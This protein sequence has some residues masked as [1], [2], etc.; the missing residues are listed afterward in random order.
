MKHLLLSFLFAVALLLGS[1]T[2]SMAQAAPTFNTTPSVTTVD[3]GKPYSYSA[4][5]T[6]EG[7]LVTTITAPTLPAWMTFST[8]GQ[9]TASLFGNIPY[10]IGIGGVAGDNNG[11]IFAITQDGTTIYQI[12]PDGT[13]TTWKTGL[14]YGS[15]YALDICDGYIY[16]PR[17]S[18]NTNSLTRIP[19]SNPAAAEETV[20]SVY[21]GIL[22][23]TDNGGYLYGADWQTA[24]IYK[25]DKTT[26]AKQVILNNSNGIPS[27][28]PFGLVFDASGNLYIA[29]W[30]NGTILKYNGST[31]TTVLTGLTSPS[32]IRTDK[33]GNFY[34]SLYGGGVRKY[35]PDFS[36]P[37][38]VSNS[39]TDGVMS[40]SFT[41][42]G[43]LV[44]SMYSTNQIY[45]LQTGA[46]IQGTPAKTDVGVYPVVLRATNTSGYTDQSFNV[47]VQ[48]KV[49]PVITTYSPTN[50]ATS[51]VLKPTLSLVF[52]EEVYFGST[53]TIKIYNSSTSALVRSLDL[54][55]TAD[56]ALMSISTDLKTLSI[57]IDQYLPTNTILSMDISAGFVQDVYNNGIPG[58]AYSSNTW[59]FTTLNKMAQTITFP[60][61]SAKTY[62]NAAFTLGNA[63][64]DQGLTVTYTAT[65]PSV[66]SISGNQA[67][68]LKA[69]STTITA[70]QAGDTYN[71]AATSIANTLTVNKVALTVTGLTGV[72]KVYNGSNTATLS[73]T[74]AL[75][76][77]VTGDA[78]NVTLGGTPTA[79]FAQTAVGNNIAITVS[80]Y[81]ISG[82]ASGNY[83]LTQP[84]GLTANITPAAPTV[85]GIS[86]TS[87]PIAGGTSVI[88]T[89]TY[90]TAA[91]AVNFGSTNA[92]SY[93]INSATQITATAPAGSAGAV[94]IIVITVGG[95]SATSSGDQ[96]TYVAAPAVSGISPTYGPTTSGTSVVIT[97]TNLTAASAVKFGSTNATSYTV[98]SAT[99]ITASSPAGSPG[100]VDIKVTT[101]GGTSATS[102]ADQFTYI[103]IPNVSGVSPSSGPT[104]GS[105]SVVI[106]GTNLTAASAVKFGTANAASYTVNSAT[107]ITVTSP[108]GSSG[109]VDISVTTSVGTSVTNTS[110]QFTYVGAP[111]F[112][113]TPSV[114]TVDYGKPY[115]YGATATVEGNLPTTITAPTLPAWL[116]FSTAGQS[117][118]SLFGN[119]PS[120][121]SIG[122]V[123]GDNNG[124]IFA[125]TTSGTTIY[126]ILPDGTTSVWRSGLYSTQVYALHIC[127]GYI[128]I[129][130]YGDNT[131]SLTRIPLSNPAT[132]E[133]TVTSTSGGVLSLT[134]NG[135]YIYAADYI[136]G[137]IYKIDKTTKVKQVLLNTSNGLSGPFGLVFDAAGNLYMA[138]H[139]GGIILK[140][141]GST[142]TTVLSGLTYPSS[143]RTDKDGNFYVSFYGGGVRKYKPDFSSYVVVSNS[144]TDYVYSLSFTA[145]GSLVYSIFGTN[146]VYRLQ[147]GAII[148]GTPAKTDVGVHPV[149]LRATNSAGYTE[150]SFSITVED[151]VGPVIS[152]YS[153]VNNATGVAFQPTLSM[154]FDE[155]VSLGATG[156][157]TLYN[158]A[159]LI[160]SYDLSVPAEKALFVLSS[161]HKTVSVTLTENLPVNTLV[162][163]GISAGFVKDVHNNNFLGFTAASNSWRF[164]TI[165]KSTQTIT[166]PVVASKT[167]GD[168]IFTLGNSTTDR[169]LTV[170]YTAEDPSV[171]SI[172]GNQATI[173]KAG[174]T[175]ITATQIGDNS[176]FAATPVERTLNVSKAVLTAT[177]DNQTKVYGATNPT[178][179]FVY[180]GWVNGNGIAD[181]TTAPTAITTVTVTSPVAVYTGAITVSGGMDENYSFSYVAANFP[182][183]KATL[184]VT[185]DT[186]TKVYGEANPSLTFQYSGWLN[187]EDAEDL[188]TKPSA[189]TTVSV[190]SPVDVYT[191]GIT[192]AGGVD[193]NYNFSY[194]S[195]DFSVTKATLTITANSKSKI[196]GASEPVLD[197]T[198]TGT[199]FN[200][201]AYS[202]VNGVT[203][204]TATGASASF[205]THTIT[206]SGGSAGNYDV[207]HVN[208]TLTI[209]KA[210]LTVTANDKAKVYG[211]AD[212]VLDYT[213]SGTLYYTDTWSVI[214]G[215]SLSAPTDA[216]ATFGTHTITAADG[217]ADNYDVTNVNGTLTVSKAA[218]LTITANDKLKVYGASDPVLDYTSSGTLYYSDTYS[219]ISGVSLSTE[220][221]ASATFGTHTINA[222]GG[223]ADNYDVNLV[224]GTLT[225]S[226]AAAL[227]I[228]ANDK[229]KIYGASEP[230]LDYT[231]S[232]ILY[233]SDTYSVISGV[234]LSTETGA[235][236]TFGTHT[237][238]A[239]N[240]SADNYNVNHINGTLSVYKA[241]LT[242][243]ANDKAKV[244]GADDPVP[245]YT[246]AG[247]LYYSDTYS[248][249]SGVSLNTAT[250]ASASFGT[251][252]ITAAGGTAD[253]YNITHVNGTLTVSKAS[254][255]VTANDKAKIYGTADPVLDFT[256]SGTLYYTDTY[257]V[258]SEVSLSTATGASA[259]FGS[260]IITASGGT[261]DNYDVTNVNGTLTVSKAA[262]LTVT[263][264][265][266]LKVYGASDP[267]LD[268]TPSGTLYYSDTYIVINDV[269]L[270]TPTGSSASFGT[271]TITATGGSADNYDID[272]VNGTLTVSKAAALTVTANDK[273]KL[274]GASD[275]LLDYT[276]SGTLY[277]TDTYSVISEFSLST[278]T[279]ASASFG[280]HTIN[281]AGG[282][283]DNYDV[284][285]VNGTL[286]VSKA[287]LLARADNKSKIYG[288][289]NPLLTITY[290]GF[291]YSDNVDSLTTQPL[292][293]TTASSASNAGSYAV[294]LT[295]GSDNNYIINNTEATLSIEKAVLNV[296]AD[297][298]S[299]IYGKVNPEFTVSYSGFSNGDGVDDLDTMP[300]VSTSADL[301]SDAGK[302][303]ITVEGG[304]DNNYNFEYTNGTL[305]IVKADQVLTFETIP[306]GL[307]TTQSH[308]L[309]ATSTSGLPVRFESSA[310]S[311]AE[312]SGNNMA[313]LKEGNVVITAI[314]EGNQNWNPAANVT[315]TIVTLPTFENIRSLFTPNNDG[316]ND[317]WYIPDIEQYGTI[318]V[319][320]YNRFGKLLYKSS[321]YKN[322]WDGTYNGTPLPEAAYYYII[323][324]SEKGLIK[325]VVNIVR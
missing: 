134:D 106:T 280:T 160:K 222:T 108:A 67:T 242:V 173:L 325:G 55:V 247:S 197:Y 53:G 302:Y 136:T 38:V 244:Y 201:D 264:N 76:G 313:V 96:F 301:E 42:A 40:L 304:S 203:L 224:N 211:A 15:V 140:Y 234:D 227:T 23:L 98:N 228:T 175:K 66:V 317:Y 208:G 217:S 101:T 267:D 261:A 209:S 250:G 36:S 149:V 59:R 144:A 163:V 290:E 221:G 246:L 283:A 125:I 25:I 169:N 182:V 24:E 318:S 11:N 260:H 117:T 296:T 223:S 139:I 75:S 308:E 150:Q 229:S 323:K 69:G 79:V 241:S 18:E 51:V 143:I 253:N 314:Q 65:D 240:G 138:N 127:D 2:K 19:L 320:I 176:N 164:T 192:V 288:E 34:I 50:N 100:T 181:L 93:T 279:G 274:Y 12:L 167:Y 81:T 194:N 20:A 245:D 239:A 133:E 118:A 86:P 122:G 107:Q 32:S 171:V 289:T 102:S 17:Y 44:Y 316:M 74:A 105:T 58:F 212:P 158:G 291:R 204:S 126:Q 35:K 286:T 199:L 276:T 196:Y 172:T 277:Y 165:N 270:N 233:Y 57:T 310:N 206:A 103:G 257:S 184:T 30:S 179:T 61:I 7:N 4:S 1:T 292:A 10:G 112:N 321:A 190:T 269:T 147:T 282:S 120:G 305:D 285:H 154:T 111:T 226:K 324:S 21:G 159:T 88:I 189:S 319:Q 183:T 185:A 87:G 92:T 306:T 152:T 104:T 174:S 272:H 273:S 97:G 166:F 180:S 216:T 322:D 33:D 214:S 64:T 236:A 77:V 71:A 210:S 268:Y 219:V 162:S 73:G 299:R 48:D 31:V 243:T 293:S 78:A 281:A 315:Q 266:K 248:V 275:P 262:A 254:L 132:A 68:I 235:S 151:N 5:A 218:A 195:A 258:I 265:D 142:V 157:L 89:G 29:T 170:T 56:K 41:A 9:S 255:T 303:N 232:G 8:G 84:T 54:S 116:T 146:Q 37:V 83:T 26:K 153:P 237:I 256:P 114:T 220:T 109:T 155:E 177:A 259:T 298:K 278:A 47:T 123:T 119:I 14:P 178:L 230:V 205:G 148:Q 94:D 311:I 200:G 39:A 128:Y 135:N 225:V 207:T 130:R 238:T 60:S 294:T 3:Y 249:I 113:T 215:V 13:T 16:I 70:T 231:P 45:R 271:H 121:V 6:M 131:N 198:V 129:P 188:T 193:E 191:G 62:G 161:D 22:S 124:N 95:T 263:A 72:N 52:D 309:V 99:Q 91:T 168:A 202:V 145:N 46:I 251:H 156:T 295:E 141:N 28:G 43:S 287:E 307:R 80:G 186:K 90:L 300:I 110:D 137:E 297:N 49:P 213:P 252:M 284:N 63:T 85:S 82:T 27:S 187:G 115:S 312:V